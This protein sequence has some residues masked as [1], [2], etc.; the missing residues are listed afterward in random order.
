MTNS[1]CKAARP[2]M[3]LLFI[4]SLL[5]AVFA[6]P[7]GRDLAV[8]DNAAL[9]PTN[10]AI[11]S[12]FYLPAVSAVPPPP[13]NGEWWRRQ[14]SNDPINCGAGNHSCL[15][16]S[17][18]GAEF[19]C[20]DD[21]YCFMNRDMQVKCCALGNVCSDQTPCTNGEN[22]CLNTKTVT[23]TI[24]GPPDS[25]ATA[26]GTDSER[27]PGSTI[28]VTQ[29]EEPACCNRPCGTASFGCADY[30]G[31]QCCPLGSH[32]GT[33]GRCLTDVTSTPPPVAH[34][35]PS[36]CT[37][38]WQFA[39]PKDEGGGCCDIGQTCT[40]GRM[41]DGVRAPTITASDGSLIEA[42]GDG[43]LSTGAKA[44][45]G[46][47]VTAGAAAL[48]GALT[49][50]CLRRRRSAASA[51]RESKYEMANGGGD[52]HGGDGAAGV[53]NHNNNN[54]NHHHNDNIG[55][56]NHYHNTNAR[57]MRS[58]LMGPLSPAAQ[59]FHF[60]RG[61]G[62]S[63]GGG[64]V[65][66]GADSVMSG[67]TSA[68]GYAPGSGSGVSRPPL[69]Q[70]GLVYDYFGPEAVVGPY[71]EA[72]DAPGHAPPGRQA[73][74]VGGPQGPEDIVAPV[75]LH[76]DSIQ[77][78]DGGATG[79][80]G[81]GEHKGLGI[82]GQ[83]HGDEG[84]A[85]GGGYH[86]AKGGDGAPGPFELFSNPAHGSPSPPLSPADDLNDPG[87][88]GFAG[89]VSPEPGLTGRAS[90]VSPEPMMGRFAESPEPRH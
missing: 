60:P 4:I 31:G 1:Q 6:S 29:T 88:R 86:G 59:F 21:R 71:T 18:K 81:K 3:T 19:C 25:A 14:A 9:L 77:R 47:G 80:A 67:P 85:K 76:S 68:G 17:P 55:G 64:G 66:S 54:N 83:F 75:E 79:T 28:L 26:T 73:G 10:G 34:P 8:T 46:I 61:L 89:A 33:S 87:A 15:D 53:H 30:F 16:V 63:G 37:A 45:I 40:T 23:T 39:C 90:M 70:S 82:S 48:I 2:G 22:Y 27:A 56:Y 69:H 72:A 20:P 11:S 62:G 52:G 38:T 12:R 41:C 42:E 36:G 35:I 74:V 13:F 49:F 44:G 65:G 32:C 50:W 58:R 78:G 43:G 7:Q 5:G 24:T 57:G 84:K 51:S